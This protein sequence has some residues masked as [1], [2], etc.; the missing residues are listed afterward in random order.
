MFANGL[1]I[2][3]AFASQDKSKADWD[4]FV[5]AEGIREDL[6]THNRGRDGYLER[7]SFLERS[8][9]REFERE[10][11]IRLSSMNKRFNSGLREQPWVRSAYALKA[12]ECQE[13]NLRIEVILGLDNTLNTYTEYIHSILMI[14][15]G[16]RIFIL[17]I[18]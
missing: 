9:Y 1:Q 5:A 6:A 12:S 17:P 16:L 11:D 3:V 14:I 13:W 8:D 4:R 18:C 2:F 10:R 7:R 15:Y